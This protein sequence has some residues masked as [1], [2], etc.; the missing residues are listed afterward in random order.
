[1]PRSGMALWVLALVV[2]AGVVFLAI[3]FLASRYKTCPPNKILVVFGKTEGG[4]FAKCM[5]GGGAIIW[6]LIQDFS[7][8]S[9]EPMKVC[10]KLQDSPIAGQGGPEIPLSFI[11]AVSTDPELMNMAAERLV[12][13]RPSE[14]TDMAGEIIAGELRRAAGGLSLTEVSEDIDTF[15]NVAKEGIESELR[16]VGLYLMTVNVVPEADPSATVVV[17]GTNAAGN[18]GDEES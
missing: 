5:H 14:I 15:L 17:I 16:K 10:V 3:V 1:M 6:P 13:L 2:F 12:Q 4:G 18:V 11:T 9:L 8:L 7:Y